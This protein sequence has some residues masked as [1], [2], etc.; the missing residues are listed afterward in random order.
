MDTKS[1]SILRTYL[2]IIPLFLNHFLKFLFC[3]GVCFVCFVYS[4]FYKQIVLLAAKNA[5]ELIF[6]CEITYFIGFFFLLFRFPYVFHFN[7]HKTKN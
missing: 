1:S 7:S 4:S 5:S 6:V 3:F 2:Y